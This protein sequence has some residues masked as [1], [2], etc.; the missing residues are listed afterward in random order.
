[1]PCTIDVLQKAIRQAVAEAI[2]P[3]WVEVPPRPEVFREFATRLE[4]AF[5]ELA[6]HIQPRLQERVRRAVADALDKAMGR[7]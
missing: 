6:R 3:R 5:E 7:V 2:E 1:M 4:G